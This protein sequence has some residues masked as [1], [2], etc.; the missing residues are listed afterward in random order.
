MEK[1][2]R[3]SLTV[4]RAR[5]Y[6]MI[7]GS[8]LCML[9]AAHLV[10]VYA[11]G[12]GSNSPYNRMVREGAIP[13]LATAQLT[14]P[15]GLVLDSSRG[16]SLRVS[17]LQQQQGEDPGQDQ[18]SFTATV[19][20][21]QTSLPAAR[22]SL[23]DV[24]SS[25]AHEGGEVQDKLL[26]PSSIISSF[27]MSF[28]NSKLGSEP[29]SYFDPLEEILAEVERIA[30]ST[31]V[32]EVAAVDVMALRMTGGS[33]GGSTDAAEDGEIFVMLNKR[34]QSE[35][36]DNNEKRNVI[37]PVA[38]AG[39][40]VKSPVPMYLYPNAPKSALKVSSPG[41]KEQ[42][43]DQES[44]LSQ[45]D[46]RD[47]V[48]VGQTSLKI[49]RQED[50][51]IDSQTAPSSPSRSIAMPPLDPISIVLAGAGAPGQPKD[52]QPQQQEPE[53]ALLP[54]SK[55]P[56]Y[57]P[58]AITA[59]IGSSAS[60]AVTNDPL[61]AIFAHRDQNRTFGYNLMGVHWILYLLAQTLL[62]FLLITLFLGV[63]ILT[64]FVLD[65]EDDDLVQTQY[66]YWSRVVG[67]ASAT[68][69]SA[70]HGSLL[71][72]YVL[73]EEHTDWIAK[74][75]V[76]AIVVYWVGMSWIMNRMTGPLPY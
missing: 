59:V 50:P 51:S 55:P 40:A 32:S 27:F 2:E 68:I 14:P 31:E 45:K 13:P 36:K 7:A 52:Q 57:F 34:E 1:F 26:V 25:L 66:L 64:E 46:K 9:V 54:L 15:A 42:L 5:A 10:M 67:I 3:I 28:P 33:E 41:P 12:N 37:L 62:I 29:S 72:G 49:G 43:Q 53:A 35:T 19:N 17:L 23:E 20:K 73:L 71:S 38:N 48:V 61:A 39:V 6:V 18:P 22:T 69:V 65:R 70:V 8:G 24:D 30:A 47:S 16:E 76:G 58:P 63:L 75:A 44:E 11:V 21:A 56:S 60:A 74:V 4:Q